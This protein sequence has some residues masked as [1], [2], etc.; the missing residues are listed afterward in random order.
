[1]IVRV[2]KIKCSFVCHIYCGCEFDVY[3]NQTFGLL[4]V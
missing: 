4:K 1:M 3:D 2:L